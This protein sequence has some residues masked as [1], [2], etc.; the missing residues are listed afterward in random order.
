M[1]NAQFIIQ[2]VIRFLCRGLIALDQSLLAQSA[3]VFLQTFASRDLKDWHM[4]IAEFKIKMAHLSDLDRIIQRFGVFAQRLVHF[5]IA[6]EIKLI[7]VEFQPIGIVQGLAHLDTHH[8]ILSLG[9]FH[10]NIVVVIGHYQRHLEFTAQFSNGSVEL[11]LF[12]DPL[13]LDLQIIML[14]PEKITVPDDGL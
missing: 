11:D 7:A 2:A 6:F 14:R 3:Q 1:D 10:I 12:I 5:I 9:V 8:D 13:I 4:V